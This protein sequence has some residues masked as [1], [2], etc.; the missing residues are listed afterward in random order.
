[1]PEI[2]PLWPALATI[3]H[4]TDSGSGNLAENLIAAGAGQRKCV[5]NHLAQR[6]RWQLTLVR[7]VRGVEN[8][9]RTYFSSRHR[10]TKEGS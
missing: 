2:R 5:E 8:I 1:M 9:A 7:R 3:W 10:I 6:L 4:L